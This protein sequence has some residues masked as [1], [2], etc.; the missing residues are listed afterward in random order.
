MPQKVSLTIR[1]DA[2][3]LAEWKGR[4]GENL[5]AWIRERC[6][7][8]DRAKGS[9]G[10]GAVH[11]ARGGSLASSGPAAT[12]ASDFLCE[13]GKAFKKCQKWGCK[14]YEFAR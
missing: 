11:M 8:N 3:E 4:A 13:H 6:N 14:H 7:G 2:Q 1:V 5:S 9:A 10:N 12:A